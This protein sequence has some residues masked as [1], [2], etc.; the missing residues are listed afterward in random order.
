MRCTVI[1]AATLLQILQ[2]MTETT[3]RIHSLSRFD[4]PSSSSHVLIL[5][6]GLY[7]A[8]EIF[9]VW[10]L[11]SSEWLLRCC[12]AVDFLISFSELQGGF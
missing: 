4:F 1:R 3:T 8:N 9:A 11:K 10:F 2:F 12:Y 5:Q 7:R 6:Y